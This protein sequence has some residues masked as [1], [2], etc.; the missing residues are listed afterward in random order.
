[1][2]YAHFDT[3]APNSRLCLFGYPMLNSYLNTFYI[4]Y[5]ILA[6]LFQNA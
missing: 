6:I 2:V 1:M 3:S 5:I 4:N